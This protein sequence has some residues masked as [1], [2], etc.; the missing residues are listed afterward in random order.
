MDPNRPLD[1]VVDVES[2]HVVQYRLFAH[3]AGENDFVPFADG[4]DQT[5]GQ[6][7]S[8]GPLARGSEI[9]GRFDIAGN[10]RTAYRI[11]LSCSQDGSPIPGAS[12]AVTG[13]T[14]ET[15]VDATRGKVTLS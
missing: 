5:S 7:H 15:G 13:T 10:P 2:P 1:V 11:R 6:P 12:T 9:G 4:T 14:D 8:V 3:K